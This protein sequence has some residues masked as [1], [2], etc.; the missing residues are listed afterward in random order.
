MREKKKSDT[1]KSSTETEKSGI[2]DTKSKAKTKSVDGDKTSKGKKVSDVQHPEVSSTTLST[3]VSTNK[4][5]HGKKYLVQPGGKW[6]DESFEN[7]PVVST[8]ISSQLVEK[9]RV[10]AEKLFHN[11]VSLYTEKKSEDTSGSSAWIQTV[12]SSG[13]L[14]D[15]IAALSS[16]VQN[17]PIHNAPKLDT[18]INM[19]KKKGRREAL[20]AMESLKD[21]WI[22]ELL[23]DNRKLRKFSRHP[24]DQLSKITGGNKTAKNKRLL[25]WYFEDFLKKKYEEYLEAVKL[26]SHDTVAAVKSSALSAIYELLVQK[27]EQEKYLLS[28][29]VNKVGDPD[30]KIAARTSH[31]LGKLVAAHPQMK[32]V[33]AEEVETVLYRPNI[34]VKAQYYAVCF[35]NQFV[36]SHDE[37][38]L[39]A[40][41]IS[42]YFAFFNAFVKKKEIDGKMLSALLTGVNRAYP[43]AKVD[44]ETVNA[45]MDTIFR[46]IHIAP[47]QT[48]LQALMLLHQVMDARQAMSDRY[49]MALYKKLADSELKNSPKQE[50]FLNLLFK[51]LKADMVL[52]RVK[53]FVKRLLQVCSCQQPSF[54]CASLF[55]VSELFRL[56]DGLKALSRVADRMP[57]QL[58][59]LV[60]VT[61]KVSNLYASITAID[62]NLYASVTAIDCN[63][64]A[65]VTATV[66]SLYASVM[67][68]ITATV[69]S[70]YAS[71]T[72]TVCSLYASVTATV[73]NLYA[74]ITATVCSLYASVTATVCSLYA[75]V[76][77]TDCNLYASV[78]ATLAGHYHPSVS[79][80]ANTLLNDQYVRYTGNPLQDFT[81]IRFL[82]RFVYRNPKKTITE[83][84]SVMQPKSKSYQ[85]SGVRSLLV[86]S[87]EFMQKA[88][89]E[90]PLDEVF[91]HRYFSKKEEKKKVVVKGDIE[92]E[93]SDAS[94]VEDEEFD[95]YLDELE[96]G[97]IG[98]DKNVDFAR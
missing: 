48:G 36:L 80:F 12:I 93:D 2:K 1:K 76:T 35:L 75:S 47:F 91:F 54:V 92:D 51:S 37:P 55:L 94:S 71:V 34:G 66:C 59:R 60:L 98:V 31:L 70:L 8:D 45:Q 58:C 53:A 65:S 49:Y 38:E 26:L 73:C 63:L 39:A 72:A 14:G 33:V 24:F 83:R 96:T 81:L 56:K 44:D 86:N 11:D 67:L 87:E 16:M 50:M 18:M 90:V 57:Q 40:K 97:E 88:E 22:S 6:L 19:C 95:E 68:H 89:S 74:S 25:L 52:Q 62:C 13:T 5:V 23:P 32:L 9:Y 64:Y 41:L 28:Q 27:P 29:L 20:M 78:T 17:S 30:Y 69:C 82:D 42:I 21:L 3:A 43:F 7:D 79:H 10:M 84:V 85:P 77:A 46:V 4:D 15:K 61:A